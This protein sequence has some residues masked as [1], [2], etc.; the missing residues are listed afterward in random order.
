MQAARIRSLGEERQGR[1]FAANQNGIFTGQSDAPVPPKEHSR[2]SLVAG[3]V[4]ILSLA[5]MNFDDGLPLH[6]PESSPVGSSPAF[7][8]YPVFIRYF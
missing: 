1:G 7:V 3:Q 5:S 4:G 2:K 8:L 6:R